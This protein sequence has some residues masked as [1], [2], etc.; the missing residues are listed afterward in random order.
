M[1]RAALSLL[2]LLLVALLLAAGP[3]ELAP[4]P[5][6]DAG[7]PRYSDGCGGPG[8][9]R[10]PEGHPCDRDADCESGACIDCAAPVCDPD[11]AISGVRCASCGGG[12]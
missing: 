8:W 2:A 1:M 10:C 5:D 4:G 7:G 11:D 9:P 12:C 3:C 6:L